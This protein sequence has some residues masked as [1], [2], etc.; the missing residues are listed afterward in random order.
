[1]GY[2]CAHS[3]RGVKQAYRFTAELTLICHPDHRGKGIGSLL[4][5]ELVKAL[6][7]P[8]KHAHYRSSV[9][10]FPVRDVKQLIAVMAVDS[11]GLD[12]GL[13]LKR[14]YEK[15]GFEVVGTTDS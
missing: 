9:A 13:A 4:L 7:E 12:G 2:T 1:V 11:T 3:F 15:H 8:E 6:S 14:F 10:S 5:G